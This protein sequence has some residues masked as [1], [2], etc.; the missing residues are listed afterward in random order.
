MAKTAISPGPL[1]RTCALFVA[2]GPVV[3]ALLA[4]TGRLSLAAA[5]VGSIAVAAATAAIVF[6]YYR[7]TLAI[8]RFL[9]HVGRPG[10]EAARPPQPVSG[11]GRAVTSA[12]SRLQRSW[13]HRERSLGL[14]LNAAAATIEALHD[15]L[16]VLDSRR[17]VTTA[18]AAAEALLGERLPGRDLADR[19]RHPDVL[20]A[21]DAVLKG[22]ASRSLEYTQPVPIERTF[23]V[24]I[25]PFDAPPDGRME[26]EEPEEPRRRQIALPAA[27]VTFHDITAI[28]RSEQMRADFVANASHELRT[29]LSTLGGFI[30]TLRG[31]ARDD[32]DAHE[33]F[34]SIMHE[35]T[36]R[37][38]RLVS[39]LLSLSR[40]ELDEHTPPTDA[41]DV[42]RVLKAVIASL[43]IKVAERKVKIRL[44]APKVIPGVVGD[45][46]QLTQVFQNLIDNAVNYTRPGTEVVVAVK[47]V[48]GLG[49][50]R[51]AF[52]SVAVEDRGPG[53]DRGH[54]PR[55]TERF[56][57]V[58]P[59]RSRAMGGTGLGLA[60]VKHIVSRHR[61]RLTIESQVGAGSTFTVLLPT[62]PV[63]PEIPAVTRRPR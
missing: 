12:L 5:A 15:P 14:Q 31:P 57:R 2:P 4:A 46:D 16:L 63:P 30:E 56:Y 9:D 62:A 25:T 42:G 8:A 40:I 28:K 45:D 41:V 11:L 38:S 1:L 43:E 55:L 50:G 53:I 26:E 21:V 10:P 33:R 52:L 51:S 44:V 59:A 19:L 20:T 6:F 34:L 24:H 58:D 18:N 7:E 37:M 60:I 22:G 3:F 54:I 48:T 61:G 32:P 29:P 49:G 47:T 27:L 23:T 13:R 35:Q 39:D 36:S 17:S